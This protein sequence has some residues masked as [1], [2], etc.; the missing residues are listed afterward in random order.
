MSY[1]NSTVKNE[2]L[3]LQSS[4]LY[5]NKQHTNDKYSFTFKIF[6]IKEEK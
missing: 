4:V 5:S 6:L 3:T 1:K 2:Y